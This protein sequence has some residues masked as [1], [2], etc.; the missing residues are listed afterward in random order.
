MAIAAAKSCDIHVECEKLEIASSEF[1]DWCDYIGG[2]KRWNVRIN[3]LL[4]SVSDQILSVGSRVRLSIVSGESDLLTGYALC[5]DAT[6]TGNVENL[7]KGSFV[8][9]GDGDL[10]RVTT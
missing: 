5:N 6:V 10:E 9:V 2:S 3:R 1:G 8:F 4:F 7:A